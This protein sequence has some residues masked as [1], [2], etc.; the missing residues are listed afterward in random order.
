MFFKGASK[1]HIIIVGF[2]DVKDAVQCCS[3]MVRPGF[4]IL[5]TNVVFCFA[6]LTFHYIELHGFRCSSPDPSHHFGFF[7]C[8]L[9]ILAMS[10]I[11]F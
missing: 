2:L 3:F 8:V 6:L 5:N 1:D 9:F 4:K 7:C 10:K 11:R